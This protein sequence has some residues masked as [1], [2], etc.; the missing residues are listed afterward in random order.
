M[1]WH[2]DSLVSNPELVITCPDP[3]D[4][5]DVARRLEPLRDSLLDWLDRYTVVPDMSNPARV[6]FS[7]TSAPQLIVAGAGVVQA[8]DNLSYDWHFNQDLD[9]SW[10]R[11]GEE[12]WV[13]LGLRYVP[14]Q[15]MV[16]PLADSEHWALD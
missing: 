9:A 6:A 4:R 3:L 16:V 10:R 7:S 14:G 5:D 11:L 2:S 13:L 8:I 15:A 12:L 1:A